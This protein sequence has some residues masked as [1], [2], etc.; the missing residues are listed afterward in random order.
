L[1]YPDLEHFP[2]AS[3]GPGVMNPGTV[4]AHSFEAVR[5]AQPL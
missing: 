5:P 1:R 3:S 4:A 2:D